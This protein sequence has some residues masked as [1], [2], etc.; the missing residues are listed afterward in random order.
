MTSIDKI[1]SELS[2]GVRYKGG[3]NFFQ[4]ALPKKESLQPCRLY[5]FGHVLCIEP[6]IAK[7][8]RFGVV[9]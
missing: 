8:M 6:F 5:F 2:Q 7:A 3:S 9:Q 1:L 4:Y